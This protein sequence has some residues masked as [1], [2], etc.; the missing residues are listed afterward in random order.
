MI[1]P[2]PE[3]TTPRPKVRL[4]DPPLKPLG[5]PGPIFGED[6]GGLEKSLSIWAHGLDDADQMLAEMRRR[7]QDNAASLAHTLRRN[8]AFKD[9]TAT[10]YHPAEDSPGHGTGASTAGAAESLAT[11][12]PDRNCTTDTE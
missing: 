9:F 11:G 8:G 6:A 4:L 7:L 2:T 3:D 12:S 10:R 1:H 5:T